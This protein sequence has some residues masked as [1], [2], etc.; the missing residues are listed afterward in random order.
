[1]PNA[2]LGRPISLAIPTRGSV[3]SIQAAP[4]LDD[5][6]VAAHRARQVVSCAAPNV[7]VD[8][9]MSRK[10]DDQQVNIIFK[11]EITDNL[12]GMSGQDDGIEFHGV[13]RRAR[14]AA[15][16]EQPKVAVGAIHRF[17]KFVDHLGVARDLLL[18]T[19]HA[20]T[21]A[22]ARREVNGEIECLSRAIGTV[23]CNQNLLDHI[24]SPGPSAI[25]A[26]G[27]TAASDLGSRCLGMKK[28][29]AIAVGITALAI[30]VATRY[31]YCALVMTL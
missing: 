19:N 7:L 29:L 15:V 27:R 4:L 5:E 25:V 1:M 6:Y 13:Q 17:A 9:G 12:D 24:D 30:T 31:E 23:V 3:R 14:P 10:A 20:K 18:H 26:I 8:P 22:E 16:G 28:A 2:R 21:R 11:D